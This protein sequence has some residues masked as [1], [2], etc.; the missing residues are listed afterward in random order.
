MK[1]H[2]IGNVD[3]KHLRLWVLQADLV[4]LPNSIAIQEVLA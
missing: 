2:K 3:F 4:K 1:R